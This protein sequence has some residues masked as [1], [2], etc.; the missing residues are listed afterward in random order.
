[1]KNGLPTVPVFDVQIHP[2]DHDLILATHGRAI[3]IMD[4]VSALE[5]LN[6]QV[7][8]TDLKLFGTRTGIEWK[9]ANYR[10]FTGGANFFAPNAPNGLIVDYFAKAAG[11]VGIAVKDKAGNPVR[12]LNARAEAG[13]VNRT[14]WDMR[15]DPPVP[16]AGGRG[17]T[18]AGD[19]AG[20]EGRGG[21]EGGGRGGRG[22]G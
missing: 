3:W 18:G 4:N 21:R 20:G 17:I 6:D 7:L 13:V 16:P 10:G 2:R 5:E 14:T 15:Y 1:M 22:G 9:M 11:P 19:A 12:Q 8:T